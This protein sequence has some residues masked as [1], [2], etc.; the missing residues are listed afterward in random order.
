MTKK[1][2]P[3][4]KATELNQLYKELA[5]ATKRAADALQDEIPGR[6]LEGEALARF[7]AEETMVSDLTRRIKEIRGSK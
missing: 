7:E 6:A 3:P 1:I 2:I 5:E 4:A